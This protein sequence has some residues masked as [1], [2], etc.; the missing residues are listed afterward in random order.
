M[1][2]LHVDMELCTGC[3]ACELACA[4]E[5]TS[6]ELP[7]TTTVIEDPAAI[8][9]VQRGIRLQTS[10]AY[11]R[12]ER[13]LHCTDAPCVTAC[14]NGAMSLDEELGVV[15]VDAARCQGCFMCAMVCPFGAISRHP[16]TG[17]AL[18]CDGC[19]DRAL[20]GRSPAC[21]EACEAKALRMGGGEDAARRRQRDKARE[22]A[23][24]MGLPRLRGERSR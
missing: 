1:E 20:E 19:R 2:D 4:A 13:C 22:I 16:D 7:A 6:A 11:A 24:A 14:P 3:R 15:F 23:E 18:K 21:V 12:F 9:G 8:E 10:V 5:H 17:L